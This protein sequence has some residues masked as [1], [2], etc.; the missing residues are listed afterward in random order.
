[1]LRFE[2]VPTPFTAGTLS[3][4]AS[5]PPDWLAPIATVMVPVKL[6]TVFPEAS[7]AL[8][9]TAGVI[10]APASVLLGW[11]LK[12]RCVAGGGGAVMSNGSLVAPV[13]PDVVARRV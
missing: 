9:C 5:T 11:T 13:R 7:R 3:V 8:T 2:N 4:P 10:V 1:M 6:A 12:P